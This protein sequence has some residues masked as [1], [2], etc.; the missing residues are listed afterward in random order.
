M[1]GKTAIEW[2]DRTSNPLRAYNVETGKRG[3]FCVHASDG[4]RGCYAEGMNVWVGN[5][6]AYTQQNVLRVR[7][8]LDREELRSWQ[9]LAPGTK[10][11]A[12][13]MTDLFQESITDAILDEV[14]AA[15]GTSPATFQ[16]LTKRALRMLTYVEDWY[17]RTQT[18]L[19]PNLWL[20]VSIEDRKNTKRALALQ[21]TPAAV[22][23]VSYEP[24]LEFVDF[25]DF[26][27]LRGQHVHGPG[28]EPIDQIIMGGE[29]GHRARP[30]SLRWARQVAALCAR[31]ET[32]FFLKQLGARPFDPSCSDVA[33]TH[34]DCSPNPLRLKHRKGGDWD[35]WPRDLRIRQFPR[36][37][38][39]S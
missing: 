24:A 37:K 26:V 30:F 13:D 4:C 27:G 31:T 32:A 18:P 8:E 3:W 14:M 39:A 2:T 36:V 19:L 10:V 9:R 1:S 12:F 29:S 7:F 35:E 21:R 33:C 38:G 20:G 17:R 6:L 16:I 11:F 28:M 22:R 5:G 15:I 34:P 23:Y 25:A